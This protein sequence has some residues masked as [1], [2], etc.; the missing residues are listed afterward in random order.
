MPEY[1]ELRAS[2]TETERRRNESWLGFGVEQVPQRPLQ[3]ALAA[4]ARIGE[5][6]GLQTAFRRPVRRQHLGGLFHQSSWSFED[7]HVLR[8]FFDR[9]LEKQQAAGDRDFVQARLG[10]LASWPGTVTRTAP[11]SF[12]RGDFRASRLVPAFTG[13]NIAYRPNC[14]EITKEC[15]SADQ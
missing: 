10:A 5:T 15:H 9:L 4:L 7:Q 3:T 12:A 8:T 2:R 6:K 11:P 13:L 1:A 14:G